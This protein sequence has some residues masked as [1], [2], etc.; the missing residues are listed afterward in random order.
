MINCMPWGLK[1]FQEQRCLHFLTFSCYR[2]AALLG[3]SE[4]RDVFERTL[5]QARKWYGFSIAGYVVMPEHVHLLVS[6]PERARLSLALQMLKQNIARQLR[7]PEGGSFW[8]ARYYDFCVWSEAKRI[9]KLRYMHRNPVKRGLVS[10]PEQWAWSS[11]RHYLSGF[12]GMV[13][14]E[15]QWTA[16]KREQ[17]GAVQVIE[18]QNPRPVSAQNAETSTGNRT[19]D[20]FGA[21]TL[22]QK[23][24]QGWGNP[25]LRKAY[26]TNVSPCG[27]AQRK[28]Y[29]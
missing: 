2:R 20:L 25:V 29:A 19:Y 21:P 23:A 17:V 11:F 16:R 28:T 1:R 18:G 6:E 22:S 10:S 26:F 4:S 7:E 12:E 8:Q 3:T 13:E 9:E 14:I 24:R 5:E 27:T 15:S